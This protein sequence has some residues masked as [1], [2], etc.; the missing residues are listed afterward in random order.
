MPERT[1]KNP[2]ALKCDQQGFKYRR[3]AKKLPDQLGD[4]TI[5]KNLYAGSVKT[6]L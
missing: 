6:D 1:G 3:G 4:D 5:S 2:R